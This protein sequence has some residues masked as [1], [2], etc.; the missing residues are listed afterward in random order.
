M[1]NILHHR[2]QSKTTN[3]KIACLRALPCAETFIA[4]LCLRESDVLSVGVVPAP[5]KALGVSPKVFERSLYLNC[6]EA[7]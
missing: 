7:R 1:E 6:W 2:S 5:D 3:K 4:A